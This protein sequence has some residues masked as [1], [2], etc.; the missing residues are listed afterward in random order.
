MG[1][2]REIPDDEKGKK[3]DE[4]E[5]RATEISSVFYVGHFTFS[6]YSELIPPEVDANEKATEEAKM[7]ENEL[8]GQMTFVASFC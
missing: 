6:K 8:T 2:A 4:R 3:L 5:S 7:T 1:T